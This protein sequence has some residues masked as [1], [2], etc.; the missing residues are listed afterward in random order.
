VRFGVCT[1]LR[2]A[3]LVADAGFDY[4]EPGVQAFLSPQESEQK[5]AVNLAKARQAA[6][7]IRAC[8]NFLPA[9]LAAVGPAADPQAIL[10]YAETAFR[11]ARQAGAGIIVFGSSRSRT[12]PDGFDREVAR[13][14]FV[15]LLGLLG[16]LARN[17]D[18]SIALEPLNREECN[19]I[20]TLAEA[21]AIA[22][23]VAHPNVG[24]VADF[25]HMAR[26]GEDPRSILDAGRLVIHAHVAE[27]AER[28]CPGV[29]G[30]DFRPFFAALRAIG[31]SGGVS[32][33]CSWGDSMAREL[34][35]SLAI[36]SQQS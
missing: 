9:H 33:E 1:S 6:I 13:R 25:Y 20:T 8:N 11:R 30:D 2:H 22:R 23:E 10:R 34:T 19:F 7:P 3:S 21:T 16:Q 26:E 31:Y 12:I 24:V 14:Q 29:A 27:G 15:T 5:F 32:C 28:T 35:R 18:L 17:H 36:L 4:L